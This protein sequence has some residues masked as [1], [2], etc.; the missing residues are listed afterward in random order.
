[1]SC[2]LSRVSGC[3]ATNFNPWTL[4]G[5][6]TCR[7][8]REPPWPY[9]SAPLMCPYG[10]AGPSAGSGRRRWRA[11]SR[12]T[13]G[14]GPT[15][16]RHLPTGKNA[17]ISPGG[18]HH[19]NS[20]ILASVLQHASWTKLE[21]SFETISCWQ[22]KIFLAWVFFLVQSANILLQFW[23]P[24]LGTDLR[25]TLRY[26]YIRK[27]QFLQNKKPQNCPTLVEKC[28]NS[29]LKHLVL[30]KYLSGFAFAGWSTSSRAAPTTVTG[31]NSTAPRQVYRQAASLVQN[32]QTAS[33]EF[34]VFLVEKQAR[35]VL[36][37]WWD[38][39]NSSGTELQGL[40]RA[41]ELLPKWWAGI[42]L[43]SGTGIFKIH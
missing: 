12:G 13:P 37:R 3:T 28:K 19:V 20:A 30:H 5:S 41:L 40:M 4:P 39:W 32:T 15:S 26:I 36:I 42:F 38:F 34:R 27:L 25:C 21:I 6:T 31:T 8:V 43:G 2:S 23:P 29:W 17:T 9:C 1:M 18:I 10:T 35:A 24:P 16:R 14:T 7:G 11:G 22:V 33:E